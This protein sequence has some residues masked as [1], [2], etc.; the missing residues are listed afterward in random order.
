GGGRGRVDEDRLAR[1]Q[2]GTQRQR[3]NPQ[4]RG[5]RRAQ[6]AIPAEPVGAQPGR[7]AF[8]PGRAAVRQPV[9]QLSD[10]SAGR[11]ARRLQQP[12]LQPDAGAGDLHRQEAGGARGRDRA[13]LARRRPGADAAA[14]RPPGPDEAARPAAHSLRQHLAQAARRAHR[15][16]A[17]RGTPVRELM[18][19]LVSLGH[20][21]IAHIKGH[22][23]HGASQWR[24]NGYRDGLAAA[25][26]EFDP[27]LVAEGDFHYDTGAICAQRL[28]LMDDPPTAIFAANDDMA[29]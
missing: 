11:H 9:Q 3:G 1:A 13:A 19:H 10:G 24:L 14:D 6:A 17:R 5:S 8:V 21:R 4:A 7:A 26:I 15:R 29:A 25:G 23:E 20:R 16:G 22:P 2:P 12:A 27:Q 28:L 18:A